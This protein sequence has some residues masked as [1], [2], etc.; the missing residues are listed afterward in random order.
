MRF[1]KGSSRPLRRGARDPDLARLIYVITPVEE[2]CSEAELL[3]DMVSEPAISGIAGTP[4]E[5][6]DDAP[7]V[8]VEDDSA[9]GA[10]V[11]NETTPVTTESR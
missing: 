6:F 9:I 1:C 3:T 8:A 7:N 10:T 4:P 5:E 2:C 11:S